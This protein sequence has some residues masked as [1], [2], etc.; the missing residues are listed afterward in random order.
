MNT[1][2]FDR[3]R[4]RCLNTYSGTR[5]ATQLFLDSGQHLETMQNQVQKWMIYGLV[6]GVT[7]FL[8]FHLLKRMDLPAASHALYTIPC[9]TIRPHEGTPNLSEP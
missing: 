8:I 3:T 1:D 9:D 7:L 2:K 4:V 6:A 5:Q